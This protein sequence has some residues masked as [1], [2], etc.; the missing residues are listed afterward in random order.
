MF[1]YQWL[2]VKINDFDKD[3]L[4]LKCSKSL[5]EEWNWAC[6]V[7]C[8]KGTGM[9]RATGDIY[10]CNAYGWDQK[11]LELRTFD[12]DDYDDSTPSLPLPDCAGIIFYFPK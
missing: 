7:E 10:T 6:N 3:F 2:N 5:T 11:S 9:Y 1:Q 8:E 12:F 4:Q